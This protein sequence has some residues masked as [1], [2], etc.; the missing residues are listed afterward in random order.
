MKETRLEYRVVTEA[1]GQ[2]PLALYNI[3][4]PNITFQVP[5]Q[6]LPGLVTVLFVVPNPQSID[7]E[8]NCVHAGAGQEGG[9]ARRRDVGISPVARAVEVV[10]EVVS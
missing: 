10:D 4:T 6:L 7:H 3:F 1:F 9:G 2:L 8:H 5:P